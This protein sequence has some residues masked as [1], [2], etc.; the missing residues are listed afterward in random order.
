MIGKVDI[1]TSDRQRRHMRNLPSALP[2]LLFTLLYH[3]QY[4]YL[5]SALPLLL[6][7]LLYGKL[8]YHMQYFYLPS[9]LPLSHAP[10]SPPAMPLSFALATTLYLYHP[11][12]EDSA[13]TTQPSSLLN[14]PGLSLLPPQPTRLI[15]PPSSAHPAY[16]SSLLSP[17]G[18]RDASFYFTQDS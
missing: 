13:L 2:L 5:P 8:L 3:M 7:T 17:P 16:P 12:P 9:A 18:A 1:L 4:F 14:P 10:M 11:P 15:P 6:F